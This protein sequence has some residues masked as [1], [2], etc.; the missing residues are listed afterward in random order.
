MVRARQELV[1]PAVKV[2]DKTY[3]FVEHFRGRAS[4]YRQLATASED[5]KISGD[6]HE[7][8]CLFDRMADDL[9]AR[10]LVPIQK[11]TQSR[12]FERHHRRLGDWRGN[13]TAS[14][15]ATI[16]KLILLRLFGREDNGQKHPPFSPLAT[17]AL[18][19]MRTLPYAASAVSIEVASYPEMMKQMT[20][21]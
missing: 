15:T 9:R 8:A 12:K 7:I 4:A 21:R 14:R 13:K 18:C 1:A 19:Q 10:Q 20:G 17:P 5:E 16:C 11:P 3:K 6:M 2:F